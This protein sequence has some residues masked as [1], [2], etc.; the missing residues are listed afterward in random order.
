MNLDNGYEGGLEHF[1][2]YIGICLKFPI[3]KVFK[4]YYGDIVLV[5]VLFCCGLFSENLHIALD[6]GRQSQGTDTSFYCEQMLLPI[7][8]PEPMLSPIKPMLWDSCW[9]RI[10]SIAQGRLWREP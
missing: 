8:G 5:W 1:S 4:Y 3:V 7:Q 10:P 9:G 6:R 2:F